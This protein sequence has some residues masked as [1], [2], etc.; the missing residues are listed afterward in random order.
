MFSVSWRLT[1]KSQIM[2]SKVS[3]QPD[4]Q[5]VVVFEAGKRR[6]FGDI[7]EDLQLD[8]EEIV[9]TKAT[10][11]LDAERQGIGVEVAPEPCKEGC[12]LLVIEGEAQ[13]GKEVVVSRL[14]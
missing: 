7:G 12:G 6:G 13:A 11:R 1:L 3:G 9:G 8:S 10:F 14:R 4:L 2:V 5:E